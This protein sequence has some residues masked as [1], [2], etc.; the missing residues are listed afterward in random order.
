MWRSRSGRGSQGGPG[1]GR[2]GGGDPLT[3]TA[4]VRCL[5]LQALIKTASTHLCV[6]VD[7]LL[8]QQV[9]GGLRV[10]FPAAS[11]AVVCYCMT[12]QTSARQVLVFACDRHTLLTLG[13]NDWPLVHS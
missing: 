7:A 1:R 6:A 5:H 2:V 3:W 9:R 11:S 10:E 8:G 13:C 12:L 4:W